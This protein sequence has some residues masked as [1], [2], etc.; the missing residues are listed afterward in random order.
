MYCLIPALLFGAAA[1]EGAAPAAA[2]GG[3]TAL[4]WALA[5]FLVLFANF[6]AV[7]ETALASASKVRM[8]VLEEK[9]DRRAA[10]VLRL[11]E[12]FDRTIS[13]ILILTNIAHIA[14]ASLVTVAVN[15]LWGLNA[16]SV[17]ALVTTLVLFFFAEM[18][19]KSF[20]KK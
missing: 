15:S 19:P 11:L 3:S 9:G 14:A 13:A 17:G 16:V 12:G 5:A 2:G 20:A 4:L 1:A 8:K 6:I 18:L 7:A 10:L